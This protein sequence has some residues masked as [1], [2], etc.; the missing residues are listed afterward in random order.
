[1]TDWVPI[2]LVS[3][4]ALGSL[5]DTKGVASWLPMD[6]VSQAILDAAFGKETPEQ[7]LNLVHPRSTPRY[8]IMEMISDYLVRSGVTQ[9]RLPFVRVD[10]WFLKLSEA[11]THASDNTMRQIVSLCFHMLNST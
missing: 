11:S 1:M 5:P 4:I 3:S 2:M 8:I 6:A 7:A 9:E 10:E